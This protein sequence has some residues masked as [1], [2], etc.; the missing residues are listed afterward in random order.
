MGKIL[1]LQKAVYRKILFS[2]L[3]NIK[4]PQL[5]E[6]VIESMERIDR[7]NIIVGLKKQNMG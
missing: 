5:I 3:K 6:H 7:D 2:H 1:E 4:N